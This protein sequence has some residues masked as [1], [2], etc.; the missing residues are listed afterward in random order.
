[1]QKSEEGQNLGN[2]AKQS[3]LPAAGTVLNEAASRVKQGGS[4]K[5]KRKK[6][7]RSTVAPSRSKKRK[8]SNSEADSDFSVEDEPKKSIKYNF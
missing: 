2:A 3:I 5:K 8:H 7:R 4:G 1:M 6:L